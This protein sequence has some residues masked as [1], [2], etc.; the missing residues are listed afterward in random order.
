MKKIIG[1]FVFLVSVAL[2][3]CQTEKVDLG[4]DEILSEKAAQIT[5]N[6]VAMESATTELE[7]EV[8]FYA[9]LEET[10]TQW[11]RIGK[12]WKWTSKLRYKLNQCPEI[13]VVSEEGGYPKTI[14][15]NYGDSTVLR[16]GRVLAGLITIEISAPKMSRDYTR[17]VTY[18]GFSVDSLG[19]EGNSLVTVDKE[20]EVF[21]MYKS[22]FIFTLAD[23]TTV[24]RTSERT[25]EWIEGLESDDDQT[26][27]VVQ[28]TGFCN[29]EN[30]S[31][32]KYVKEI[33]EPLIRLRDCRFIVKGVV[34][35]T[36]NDVLISSLDYGDGECN[37]IAVLTKD[38]EI[39]EVDL[40]KR[41]T[42]RK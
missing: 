29:A 20:E 38:G 37:N 14:T 27:D 36:L 12:H 19:I 28:I 41:K 39:Y 21:R 23:G 4:N 7:Y 3:S 26:D 22:D 40:A 24:N 34:E 17:L 31:G 30:S 33:V 32:D 1:I 6:E 16:N 10:L 11:W 18:T 42:E 2:I 13:H 5:L 35:I 25:W 8:E 9:N 15:L